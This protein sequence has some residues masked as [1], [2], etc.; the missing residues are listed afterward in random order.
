MRWGA[1]EKMWPQESSASSLLWT[2]FCKGLKRGVLVGL[3]ILVPDPDTSVTH[4][5]SQDS[6]DKMEKRKTMLYVALVPHCDEQ[7]GIG[8]HINTVLWRATPDK[9]QQCCVLVC[10]MWRV[11]GQ[12]CYINKLN[13]C[14]L[15]AHVCMCKSV[16]PLPMAAQNIHCLL[17]SSGKDLCFLSPDLMVLLSAQAGA[18]P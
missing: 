10:T 12:N 8:G 6:G 16:L 15:Y 5:A 3:S 4:T 1:V 2:K 11:V 18:A 17:L 7:Q 13:I 14:D 9:I